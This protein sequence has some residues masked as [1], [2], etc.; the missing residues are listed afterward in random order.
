MCAV[1]D[2][3]HVA[4][5]GGWSPS[6]S[7]G[8]AFPLRVIDGVT[9]IVSAM[10]TSVP[11]L[12][13][14]FVRSDGTV[15]HMAH[16]SQARSAPCEMPRAVTAVPAFQGAVAISPGAT[17][18]L[19]ALLRDGTVRC[20]ST[21]EARVAVPSPLR[22]VTQLAEGCAIAADRS[23]SCWGENGKG[24]VGDGTTLPRETPVLVRGAPDNVNVSVGA[25]S[26]CATAG[27][28]TVRCWGDTS[29]VQ[30]LP[31]QPRRIHPAPVLVPLKDVASVAVYT[32][33]A[34]AVTRAGAVACWGG[35]RAKSD[36]P[37]VVPGFG[38]APA[39]VSVTPVA[40]PTGSRPTTIAAGGNVSCARMADATVRCWGDNDN[41]QLGDGTTTDRTTPTA[42]PYLRGVRSVH[43]GEYH[44]CAL[45]EDATL[46]CWGDNAR[47]GPV[48]VAVPGL[49]HIKQV[50]CAAT[51]TCALGE[52]GRVRCWGDRDEGEKIGSTEPTFVE[53][54]RDIDE[55]SVGGGG[56]CGRTHAS[57][58]L[59]WGANS[60]YELAGGRPRTRTAV[61]PRGVGRVRSLA[62]FESHCAVLDDGGVTCWGYEEVADVTNP[63]GKW[64]PGRA[65]NYTH[66]RSI[67]VGQ[68]ASCAILTD[69]SVSC[70]AKGTSRMVAGLSAIVELAA[71]RNHFCAR[72]ASG[73]VWCWGDNSQGQ[74]GDG[75]TTS[76][77]QPVRVAF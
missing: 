22:G 61:A 4:C 75:T 36:L 48:P 25:F 72:D 57:T 7:G 62:G 56:R 2:D 9:D 71:G 68:S 15:F 54:A 35:K 8:T 10:V 34:C 47:T 44:A 16:A 29:E 50:S 5:W 13:R 30:V 49:T 69:G 18:G 24:Q 14:F 6:C 19:C 46:Q 66:V 64:T 40:V 37:T 51:M 52:D 67:V 65:R 53:G 11:T 59:C 58:A 77:D 32:D 39:S 3:G 1:L 26:T 70:F 43:P 33:D 63:T 41:S 21:L 60:V 17:L 31:G 76:R 74:L 23:L 27:D 55:L 73:A 20:A 42:S 38:T 28:G 12:D 45:M